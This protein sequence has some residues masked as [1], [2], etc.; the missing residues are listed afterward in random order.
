MLPIELEYGTLRVQAFSNEQGTTDAQLST[1]L[2]NELHWEGV[3]SDPRS[4]THHKTTPTSDPTTRTQRFFTRSQEKR[5][6]NTRDKKLQKFQQE[7]KL[8]LRP[9]ETCGPYQ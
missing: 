5:W 8:I 6:K 7:Y 2:F 4:N 3:C 9:N 1:D